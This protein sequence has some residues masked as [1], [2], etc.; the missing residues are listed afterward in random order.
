MS[1]VYSEVC[2]CVS[3][4]SESVFTV[5][6]QII[7]SNYKLLKVKKS[8]GTLFIYLFIYLFR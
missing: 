6:K 8:I 2:L 7:F 4:K 1:A 3:E 5:C